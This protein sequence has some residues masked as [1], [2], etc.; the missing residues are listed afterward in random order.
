[1]QA[2][3][4]PPRVWGGCGLKGKF[5]P[6]GGFGHPTMAQGDLR[7]QI[8]VSLIVRCCESVRSNWVNMNGKSLIRSRVPQECGGCLFADQFIKRKLL[9]IF[10]QRRFMT[11]KIC[12][13]ASMTILRIAGNDRIAQYS[14]MHRFTI[15]KN[16]T[17][18]FAIVA[19]G[20][21]AG[22]MSAGGEAHNSD[23]AYI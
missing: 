14:G 13:A 12:I 23:S 16:I 21:M 18:F 10:L 20:I 5:Q 17:D 3:F 7:E 2:I 11:G 6:L 4:Y 9:N 19:I 22:Q 8:V 1:M 15:R